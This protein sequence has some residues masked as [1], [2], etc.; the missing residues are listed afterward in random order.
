MRRSIAIG[1]APGGTGKL[2]PQER[3]K[4]AAGLVQPPDQIAAA[5]DLSIQAERYGLAKRTASLLGFTQPPI[6]GSGVPVSIAPRAMSSRAE[7]ASLSCFPRNSSSASSSSS[8]R[9]SSA[10]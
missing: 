7:A 10:L 9:S 2:F 6:H 3:W 1:V 5:R 4:N 8:S